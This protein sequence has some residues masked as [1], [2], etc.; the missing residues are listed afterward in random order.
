MTLRL[1]GKMTLQR[2]D[3]PHSGLSPCVE[4]RVPKLLSTYTDQ[5]TPTEPNAKFARIQLAK[6]GPSAVALSPVVTAIPKQ[7]NEGWVK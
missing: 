2:K 3:S 7:T 4:F 5:M 1:S 6:R